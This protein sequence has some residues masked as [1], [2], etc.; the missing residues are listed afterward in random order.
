MTTPNTAAIAL[1]RRIVSIAARV[2]PE[3]AVAYAAE[4]DPTAAAD[5]ARDAMDDAAAARRGDL[6][7]AL[8]D[9]SLTVVLGDVW[10][11]TPL[12]TTLARIDALDARIDAA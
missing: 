8:K 7:A 6:R 12:R 3:V 1:H 2:A 4:S 9:L 10:A 11:G 5:A